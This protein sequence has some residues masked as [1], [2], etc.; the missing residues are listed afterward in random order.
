MALSKH[1]G[2]IMPRECWL[3]ELQLMNYAI[4]SKYICRVMSYQPGHC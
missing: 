3:T 1:K 2:Y 4:T